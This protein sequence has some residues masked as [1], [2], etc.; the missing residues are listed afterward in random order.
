MKH[1]RIKT[2]N[3]WK[4]LLMK[5]DWWVLIEDCRIHLLTWN[6]CTWSFYQRTTLQPFRKWTML[7]SNIFMKLVNSDQEHSCY[8]LSHGW[9][10]EKVNL[11]GKG[12]SFITIQDSWNKIKWINT[13]TQMLEVEAV[14]KVSQPL[15]I[16]MFSASNSANPISPSNLLS[17]KIKAIMSPLGFNMM[18]KNCGVD[19]I[20]SFLLHYKNNKGVWSTRETF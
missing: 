5:R 1:Y 16:E 11:I 19:G 8:C 12:H 3:I 15:I 7:K 20:R 6:A 18:Q 10:M 17:M 4:N 14:L 13:C 2:C 9:S